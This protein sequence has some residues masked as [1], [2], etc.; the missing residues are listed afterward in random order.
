MNLNINSCDISITNTSL[1]KYFQ[2]KE[3]VRQGKLGKTSQYWMMYMDSVW[4]VLHCLRATKMNDFDLHITTS[5][6]NMCPLFFSMD[7]PNYARHL[8]SYILLLLNLNESH[9]GAEE[10]LR[11]KGFSVCRSSVPGARNAVDLTIE[12]T[13]NRQAK[14]KG[15]IVGFSQNQNAAA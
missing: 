10:L 8:T 1:Q 12:Q 11:N 9:P 3:D 13:I 6:E 7:H 15:G 4:N 5:L 14:C 2:F